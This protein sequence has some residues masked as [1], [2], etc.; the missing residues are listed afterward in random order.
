MKK[1]TT[2]KGNDFLED[3]LTKTD[4]QKD[5]RT[6]YNEIIDDIFLNEIQE[7]LD[8]KNLINNLAERK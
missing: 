4:G 7:N 5:A 2:F 3:I 1:F 6:I 8:D